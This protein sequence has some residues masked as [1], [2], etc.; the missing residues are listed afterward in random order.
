MS[1]SARCLPALPYLIYPYRLPRPST[2]PCLLP[3]PPC[4]SCWWIEDSTGSWE[5]C[6]GTTSPTFSVPFSSPS[7]RNNARLTTAV[8]QWRRR[9]RSNLRVGYPNLELPIPVPLDQHDTL[10]P[11]NPYPPPTPQSIQLPN[12]PDKPTHSLDVSAPHLPFPQENDIVATLCQLNEA[13]EGL[14]DEVLLEWALDVLRSPEDWR[15]LWS[16]EPVTTPSISLTPQDHPLLRPYDASSAN[17]WTTYAPIAL[18]MSAHSVDELPLDTLNEHAQCALAPSVGNWVMWAPLAQPQ[19]QHTPH[20]SLPT[21]ATWDDLESES[22]G[23][24]G[25]NVMVEEPPI[26]FSPFPLTDCTL[27][28]H[29][30]FD[31]FIMVAFPDLTRD[32]DNQI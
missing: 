28:S 23:Y 9:F 24:D 30:S 14:A 8:I 20:L 1:S 11:P 29:F 4:L 10:P 17:P 7:P 16:P 32:L 3:A 2:P 21:W 12:W 13:G 5:L 18:S 26:S 25:G 19:L 27:Y 31:D 15:W 6:P 22:Q